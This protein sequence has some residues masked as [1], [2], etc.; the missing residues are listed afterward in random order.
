MLFVFIRNILLP[1]WYL[2]TVSCLNFWDEAWW[3]LSLRVFGQLSSFLLLFPQRLSRYVLRPSSIGLLSTCTR[4]WLTESEQ[5]T[6]MESIKD[7]VWSSVK[8]P[9][10]DKLLKKTGG[11]IGRNV[12]GITIKMKTIARKPLKIKIF[13]LIWRFICYDYFISHTLNNLNRKQFY[14]KIRNAFAWK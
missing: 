12:V 8:L 2:L 3:L 6:P 11:H 4:L 7:V 5:V 14:S 13:W 1:W 9:E 10:F